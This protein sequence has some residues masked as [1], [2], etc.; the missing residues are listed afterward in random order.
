MAQEGHC[1]TRATA[2]TD[3]RGTMGIQ[4]IGVGMSRRG[5]VA[6]SA[7]S[8]ALV[9]LG[10]HVASAAVPTSTEADVI[11]VGAGA[12]GLAAAAGAGEAGASVIVLEAADIAGGA[13]LISGGHLAMLDEELNATMD[14]NDEALEAYKKL[15]LI[16]YHDFGP[17]LSALLEQ[18][19]EYQANGQEKGRFDSI[20]M[21]LVDMY[22]SGLDGTGRLTDLDGVPSNISLTL[23]TAALE[24]NMDVN[25][26]LCQE[27]GMQLEDTI[28][29][30]HGNT[31]V[32]KG[33]G[34]VDALSACCEKAGATIAY[35]MR[36]TDL[37]VEDGKVTG[38]VAVDA[39]GKQVTFTAARGVVLATGSFTSNAQMCASY[40]RVGEAL[41]DTTPSDNVAT[42]VGD[43][44]TMALALNA[45]TRDMQFVNTIL[46][47]YQ[48]GNTATQMPVIDGNQQ[49]AVNGFAE[50]F[51]SDVSS[52]SLTLPAGNEP[53]GIIYYVGDKKM[54]DA[55]EEKS[56]GCVADYQERGWLYVADT[57]EEAAQAAGLDPKT[58]A[59][60]VSKFNKF[61]DTGI[62]LE[63]G[64]TKF[65]GKVEEGPFL[66][67]KMQVHYH[68][69][70]GG[71]VIDEQARVHDEN[72]DTIP[73]LYAAGDVTW[74]VEGYTHQSGSNLTAD[75]YFGKV[76]GENAAT[77]GNDDDF[78]IA[79][80]EKGQAQ[81]APSSPYELPEE[82]AALVGE[83]VQI[84]AG[85]F[86][87]GSPDDEP[88]RDEN[89]GPLHEVN[90]ASFVVGKMPVTVAQWRAF[91]EDTGREAGEAVAMTSLDGMHSWPK[92]ASW[93][94]PFAGTYSPS[95]NDPVT[96]VDYQ[97]AL[98]YTAWLEE[99]TGLPF[100][101]LTEAEYEYA[102][103]AGSTEAYPCGSRVTY[104]DANFDRHYGS[105]TTPAGTFPE[106]A[107]GLCDMIG[108]VWCWLQDDYTDGT[109]EGAPTDGS[110]WLVEGA[111]KKACRGASW[112][113]RGEYLRCANRD[114]YAPDTKASRLGFRV[115]LSL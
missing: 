52:S 89:E 39:N 29:K 20:E 49:L 9:G 25:D 87:M 79:G 35:G 91:V 101:L 47:A 76:A 41:D 109:Y 50:R 45:A 78:Q 102:A 60:T 56:A 106:N 110:A 26:W 42:N 21:M 61:V 107:W 65:N 51:A 10:S 77:H 28:Y 12:A 14:R 66:I 19:D 94:N 18:I 114:G 70:L 31:P 86:L 22:K 24:H 17:A 62:D 93:D 32:G 3:E 98:D 13:A 58:L 33:V 88:F 8:A 81:V 104:D 95:D 97:D 4:N 38:V 67:A 23:C 57:L 85:T 100:R 6:G 59:R 74:G 105:R 53:G 11:V 36:A 5:F 37:V 115:A 113:V 15:P 1:G 43:G 48:N 30:T 90:L 54:A 55:M 112:N 92:I 40:Q 71:L 64:R 69:S 75:V 103:R 16:K 44:I 99:K 63:F 111:E 72:G 34:L 96:C 73:G 83:L 84:P 82:Q 68:L 80:K 108:N 7:A 2:R 27:G 46:L